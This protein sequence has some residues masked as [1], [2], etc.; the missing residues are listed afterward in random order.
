M[1]RN[2]ILLAIFLLGGFLLW[3]GGF[4][5]AFKM[6]LYE[7]IGDVAD[8]TVGYFYAVTSARRM[9]ESNQMLSRQNQELKAMIESVAMVQSE[10]ESLKELIGLRKDPAHRYAYGKVLMGSQN[11]LSR[12]IAIGIG[13]RDGMREGLPAMWTNKIYLGILA[14]VFERYS[15]IRTLFDTEMRIEVRIGPSLIPALLVGGSDPLLD[16]IP[17]EARVEIGDAVFTAPGYQL[18]PPDLYVG[19]IASIQDYES[20]VVKRARI[21]FPYVLESIKDVFIVLP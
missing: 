7:T 6:V 16:F 12:T 14:D 15:L 19:K 8:R 2:A 20:D 17:K 10:I 21:E 3:K 13:V 1:K 5:T 4:L 9:Y 11:N 18:A